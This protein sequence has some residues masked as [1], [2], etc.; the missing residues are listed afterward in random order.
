MAAIRSRLLGVL[1]A[2]P[3]FPVGPRLLCSAAPLWW[4]QGRPRTAHRSFA[5]VELLSRLAELLMPH[6]PIG[7]S[8]RDFPVEP[9]HAWGSRWLCPD[10]AAF[11]VLKQKDAALFVEYDGCHWHRDAQAKQRDER[12][13]EALLAYAPGGSVVLRIDHVTQSSRRRQ[14]TTAREAMVDVCRWTCA[15]AHDLV[16][17]SNTVSPDEP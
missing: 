15:F 3:R 7:E 9:S 5:E 11:G 2:A 6:E 4:R 14:T 1:P 16:A 10:I 8:F 17:S 12:K 13:T